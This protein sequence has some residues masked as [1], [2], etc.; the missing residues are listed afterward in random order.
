[1]LLSH[2]MYR[3]V[4]FFSLLIG[5]TL[6]T[7]LWTGVQ[8][9]NTE[10]RSSYE[11]ARTALLPGVYDSLERRDG[12]PIDVKTYAALQRAGWRTSPVLEGKLQL[13]DGTVRIL[14]IDPVTMPQSLQNWTRGGGGGEDGA[15]AARG[16]G[17]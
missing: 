7:G 13:D 3:P 17:P 10:A 1:M 4:Q 12:Q 15:A 5:L 16:Q 2:W 11:K 9:I 6:A 14:A 8:A